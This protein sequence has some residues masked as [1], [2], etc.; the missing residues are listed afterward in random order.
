M[1][2][3]LGDRALAVQLDGLQL[4]LLLAHLELHGLALEQLVRG[5]QLVALRVRLRGRLLGRSPGLEQCI[6][7]LA[8]LD[9]AEHHRIT[10]HL[11]RAL[12]AHGV[13]EH[14]DV[15]AAFPSQQEEDL[16]GIAVETE[17]WKEVRLIEDAAA[18]RKNALDVAADHLGGGIAEHIEQRAVRG[19]NRAVIGEGYESARLVIEQRIERRR[20]GAH[21]GLQ[22]RPS[23]G[24]GICRYSRIT[25][26][27]SSGWLM[28]GQ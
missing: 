23:P 1:I 26:M 28:C 25:A 7:E 11:A 10:D 18:H 12:T 16:V 9:E 19:A 8:A 5:Q 2:R 20:G 24:T 14:R 3:L 17:Q 15:L 22:A 6:L 13:R 21:A 27:I 4:E